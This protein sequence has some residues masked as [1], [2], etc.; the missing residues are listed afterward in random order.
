[1]LFFVLYIG[2]EDEER[3]DL[4]SV[5]FLFEEMKGIVVVSN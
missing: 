3:I 1:M 5:L 4:C 2:V